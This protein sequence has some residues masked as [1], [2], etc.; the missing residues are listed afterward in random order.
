MEDGLR[1]EEAFKGV[2]GRLT[3]GQPVP[4]EV[5]LGKINEGMGNVGVVRNKVLIEIGEDKEGANVLYLGW[6]RPACN[7]VE[8]N[9]V[10]SQ[11]ARFYYH[12]KVFDFIRGKLALFEFQVK[13]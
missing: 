2:E 12:S 4:G 7:S 1:E 3:R 13:V 8:L 5:F 9:R 6:S 11:L 10:H